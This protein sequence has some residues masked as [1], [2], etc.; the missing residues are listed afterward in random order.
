MQY[1]WI[2]QFFQISSLRHSMALSKS[3]DI[4]KRSVDTVRISKFHYGEV[5]PTAD[6]NLRVVNRCHQKLPQPE[7]YPRGLLE[8][9][10]TVSRFVS[11]PA[12]WLR[13]SATEAA[14]GARSRRSR[15]QSASPVPGR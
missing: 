9:G 6:R 10:A 7:E 14:H 12:R 8:A 1:R 15:K 3:N 2:L 4:L 13:L 5:M 11:A